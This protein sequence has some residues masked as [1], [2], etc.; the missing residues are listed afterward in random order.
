MIRLNCEA[1]TR[2]CGICMQYF[3]KGSRIINLIYPRW[4]FVLSRNLR[5]MR[6][7]NLM[8]SV[9]PERCGAEL[10]IKRMIVVTAVCPGP[11]DTEFFQVSGAIENAWKKRTMAEVAKR[12]APCASGCESGK[13]DFCI[14][15]LD[16]SGARGVQKLHRTDGLQRLDSGIR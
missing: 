8:Y 11:V 14:W 5:F 7:Q 13:T 2:M 3:S 4:R 16:E 1:L 6:R 15:F 12:R 10:K 9:F